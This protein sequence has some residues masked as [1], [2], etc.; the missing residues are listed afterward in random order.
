[1][2]YFIL[3]FAFLISTITLKAQEDIDSLLSALE[4]T[5]SDEEKVEINL[6][7]SQKYQ[8]INLLKSKFYAQKVIDEYQTN[9]S[10]KNVAYDLLARYY[11]Y[12]SQ[13]DSALFYFEKEKIFFQKSNDQLKSASIGISIGSVLLRKGD[14]EEAVKE[15]LSSLSY[16]E[17]EKLEIESAKCYTNLAT[18]F[19]ELEEYT[20]A[21]EYNQQAL[22]L[23]RKHKLV[24][25]QSIIL[26]NLATQY[27]RSGD[28][29]NAIKHYKSAEDFALQHDNKRS[30]ALVYNNLGN[31]YLTIDSLDIA[32]AY[33]EKAIKIKTDLNQL[34]GLEEAYY[35]LGLIYYKKGEYKQALRYYNLIEDKVEGFRKV[36]VMRGMKSLYADKGQYQKALK[37]ANKAEIVADSLNQKEAR[38]SITELTAKYN[39]AQKEN[40]I[41]QLKT[42]NQ[43]LEIDKIQNRTWLTLLGG[44]L[45]S[46]FLLVFLWRNNSKRKVLITEQQHKLQ[47]QEILSK[48]N[49]QEQSAIERMITSQELERKRIAGDLHDSLGSKLATL[50]RYIE[51]IGVNSETKDNNHNEALALADESYSDVRKI[52]HN[53]NSGVLAEEGLIP[54]LEHMAKHISS[55]NEVKVEVISTVLKKRLSNHVEIQLFRVIQELLSNVIKHA[56]AKEANIQLIDHGPYLT[57][58]VEDD[59]IGITENHAYNRGMGMGSIEN[60]VKLINGS[61]EIDSSP[62]AGTSV[63]INIP[64]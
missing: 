39:S 1:V 16:F 32:K 48:L 17:S 46:T 28:R 59:G 4:F 19:A 21:I 38:K 7:L 37:Y 23:S 42:E 22:A 41:L 45:V 12:S 6:V 55:M 53:I 27:E 58:M 14:H 51:L 47:Q 11:F 60:R 57:V 61:Y 64:I 40:E 9:D 52:A 26:P 36:V 25:V 34:K 54:A 8:R 44:A 62:D 49:Q 13:L 15:F 2:Q 30:L 3:I 24:A 18:A 43:A 63:I 31:L 50:K 35:N 10:L 5:N 33:T 20:T 29:I 56:Q